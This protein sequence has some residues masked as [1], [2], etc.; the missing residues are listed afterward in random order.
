MSGEDEGGGEVTQEGPGAPP[1]ISEVETVTLGRP[2]GPGM[3][4][5]Y[6][7]FLSSRLRRIVLA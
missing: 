7:E 4:G 5:P 2:T 6:L 1:H 3:P